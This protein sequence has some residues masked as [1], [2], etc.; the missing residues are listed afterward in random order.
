MIVK[1]RKITEGPHGEGARYEDTLKMMGNEMTIVNEVLRFE[2]PRYI[3]WAQ[4]DKE[5]PFYTVESSYELEFLDGRTRFT[6]MSNNEV[7]GLFRL[8]S[9]LMRWYFQNKGFPSMLRQLKEILEGSSPRNRRWVYE[10]FGLFT[11]TID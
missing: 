8:F 2:P 1:V 6:L 10:T 11:F 9:P 3:S 4:V 7:T 5:G